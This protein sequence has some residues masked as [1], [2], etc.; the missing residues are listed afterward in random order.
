[1]VD[2][3]PTLEPSQGSARNAV[4]TDSPA[5]QALQQALVNHIIIMIAEHIRNVIEDNRSDKA[6][7]I[8]ATGTNFIHCRH[9]ALCLVLIP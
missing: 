9:S 3:P 1:M 7:G 4:N 5:K 6:H 2:V 8:L